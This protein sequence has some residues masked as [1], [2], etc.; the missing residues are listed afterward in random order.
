MASI[1]KVDDLRGN[2]SAG[3]ITI[4]DGGGNQTYKLQE[5][6]IHSYVKISQTA[7]TTGESHNVS[8]ITDN[9][10][11]SFNANYTNAFE[12]A[13]IPVTMANS[14]YHEN[15]AITTTVITH[16]SQNSSHAAA[17]AG[18]ICSMAAGDLA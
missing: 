7:A 17:D 3:D 18:R 2:T 10:A 5:G 15:Y 9:S 14:G 13:D 6:I 12:S 16:D 4:T 8:S 1:L 11:G